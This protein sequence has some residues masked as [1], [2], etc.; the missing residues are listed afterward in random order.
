MGFSEAVKSVFSKYFQFSGRSRRSEYWYYTLFAVL[1]AIGLA[2]VDGALFGFE[3]EDPSVFGNIFGLATFIPGLAVSVRRLHDTDRSG[4][5]LLLP[6]ALLAGAFFFLLSTVM[7]GAGPGA[8]VAMFGLVG[9]LLAIGAVIILL[10]WLCTD[11]TRGENRFGP[12]P[13]ALE[14]APEVFS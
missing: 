13:K 4:W 9:M 12:D 8:N 2:I 14:A 3:E 10:V 11:G 1:V 5:W 7:P 6:Y